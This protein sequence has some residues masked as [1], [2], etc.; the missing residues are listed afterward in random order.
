LDDGFAIAIVGLL[1]AVFGI[2]IGMRIGEEL[3]GRCTTN[4][5]YW[6]SNLAVFLVGTLVSALVWATG[7]V[8]LALLTIGVIAGGIAG[9]KFG[10]GESVGPWKAHDR[11]MRVNKDQI[12]NNE[13]GSARRRRERR[14]AGE[15]EPELMSV[16][17]PEAGS[18]SD[19][20]ADASARTSH[21][22]GK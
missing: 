15:P 3:A 11:F 4:K 12:K 14:A 22:K 10:Y 13:T 17:M 2:V 21:K 8:V 18:S 6:L 1:L 19:D 16:Q 9:L 5:D 20:G 7:L